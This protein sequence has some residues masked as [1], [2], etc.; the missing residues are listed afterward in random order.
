MIIEGIVNLNKP[1]NMTSHSCVQEIRKIVGTRRVG[2][3][4]TLDPQADGVLPVCIGGAARVSEYLDLDFKKYRCEMMLG[5]T[6]ETQDVWGETIRDVR[7]ELERR[8]DITRDCVHEVFASFE[9]LIEQ[10]PPMYSAVRV[11]GKRLYE[12]ARAGETVERKKR[13]VFIKDVS[14]RKINL[15]DYT[16]SFD[17]TCSKGTYVRAVCSDV[18]EV[19]GCGGAMSSLTRLASGAF[20]IDSAIS[21][22]NFGQLDEEGIS[23]VIKPVDYPL[24]HFGSAVIPDE[25]AAARFVNGGYIAS[26]EASF[27]SEPIYAEAAPPFPIRE[28]FK[29]AYK[30]YAARNGTSTFLG[31]AFCDEN[32]EKFKADKVFFRG[33]AG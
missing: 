20:D 26:S 2:H 16:I 19:L 21:L 30:V 1:K 9:G 31:V 27:E 32:H 11:A 28:E 23:S 18:G 8:A 3:I 5:L 4:G 17:I 29:R 13:D 22:E 6:T 10:A 12:Y 7:D 14:I 15:V 25:N 24:V 33:S